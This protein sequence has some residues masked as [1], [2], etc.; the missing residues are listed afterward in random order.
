M[1]IVSYFHF[2]AALVYCT[3]AIIALA[4]NPRAALN[5]VSSIVFVCFG[6]WSCAFTVVHN[7]VVSAQSAQVFEDIGSIGWLFFSGFFL[8]FVFLFIDAKRLK[9]SIPV[10]L[11]IFIIPLLLLQRQLT[12]NLMHGHVLKSY[13]W[14]AQWPRS[15]WTMLFYVY[16]SCVVGIGF[17]LLVRFRTKT[18][19]HAK[20]RQVE[21]LLISGFIPLVFGTLTNV[22]LRQVGIT[23]FPPIAD[24]LLLTWALGLAYS[25]PKYRFLSVNPIVAAEKIIGTMSDLV[26]L[27]DE[28]GIIV[29]V[30]RAT[31]QTLGYNQADLEGKPAT[32]IFPD[33]V[34]S[35]ELVVR[36]LGGGMRRGVEHIFVTIGG[37]YLPVNVTASPID[38]GG[39]VVVA[40]DYTA[41]KNAVD[42]LRKTKD[43][44]EVVVAERTS[45]LNRTNTDLKAE[46]RSRAAIEEKLR[47]SEERLRLLFEHAPDAWYLNDFSGTL[48]DGNK[49]A[50]EIIGYSKHELVGKGL[51]KSG[52]LSPM[53]LVKA[54]ALLAKNMLGF[55]TGPDEFTLNRKDGSVVEVEITTHPVK[56]GGKNLVLGIARNITERKRAEREKN[57]LEAQLRQSQKMEAIGQLA[58]GVAHD[59]NNMLAAVLG[60]NDLIRMKFA[61]EHPD[62]GKYTGR[63]QDAGKSMAGLTAK[64]LAFARKGKFEMS[65]VDVNEIIGEVVK[66]LEHSIDK[67][68][69]IV[70]KLSEEPPFI[71]CDKTQL[72]N[73]LLNLAVNAR[74]AMPEG[75]TLRFC[76]TVV[77]IDAATGA[78]SGYVIAPGCYVRIEVSDTV[79]GMDDTV[80][81]KLF[82]PF[83]TTK[84]L[85]KGTGLG[86]ASVYGTVKGHSG[87]IEVESSVGKGATFTMHFPLRQTPLPAAPAAS[88][89]RREGKGGVLVVD[90]EE[91][92]RGMTDE[93][94]SDMGCTVFTA[95]DGEEALERY[96]SHG[97]EIDLVILDLVM[98][99]LHGYE[100]FMKLKKINPSVKVLITSGYAVDGEA[101]KALDEGALGF[102]QKPFELGQFTKIVV[103]ALEGKSMK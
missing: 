21:I 13:G 17:V 78:F 45:D 7:P 84:E 10:L 91:L 16:Y 97:Q 40:R 24:L 77:S 18:R 41:E 52:L 51:I 49:K 94:L 98:P 59:F 32:V 88:I 25:I 73:A 83:F 70:L 20:R 66:L 44:L 79:T 37:K 100:C 76:S 19:V 87:Y 14:I 85:G 71:L 99:K 74:D 6:V 8:W 39:V 96:R 58:G 28:E 36:M 80:K 26:L 1:S 101:K 53:Q 47:S 33:P 67:R 55:P 69:T 22:I 64:L 29:S 75:G 27:L 93:I 11:A 103:C 90:D 48:I 61:A 9:R 34:H 62:L 92:V 81:S 56:I 60:F 2:F 63:I 89:T 38:G 43:D 57:E 12:G 54:T 68:I 35:S 42:A 31:L 72:Q 82:E 95:G 5:R 23:D 4:R 86:L 65:V 15:A 102:M 3:L 46:I 30:N 50:E